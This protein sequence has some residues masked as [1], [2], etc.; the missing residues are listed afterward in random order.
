MNIYEVRNSRVVKDWVGI[1][2]NGGWVYELYAPSL[3]W[4]VKLWKHTAGAHDR[5]TIRKVSA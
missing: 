2:E 3:A 1:F 4:A 5:A